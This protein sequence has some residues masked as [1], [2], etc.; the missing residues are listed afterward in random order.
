MAQITMYG[1][2]NNSPKTVVSVSMTA[3]D[4][5][6][7][8]ENVDAL[9]APPNL[10]TLGEDEN[11]EVISYS[12]KESNTLTGVVRGIKGTTASPWPAGTMVYRAYTA[13]DHDAFKANIEDL[14]NRKVASVNNVMPDDN[15]NILLSA[16][17]IEETASRVF[18]SPEQKTKIDTAYSTS[19]GPLPIENGGTGADN[20]ETARENLDVPQ[21]V[22]V[23]GHNTNFNYTSYNGGDANDIT[24]EFHEFVFNM[25][26]I[27]SSDSGYGFLDVSTTDGAG[28]APSDQGV[29]LQ[30]FYGYS[31]GRMFYRTRINGT[32]WSNWLC[33]FPFNGTYSGT[34]AEQTI[35]LGFQPRFVMVKK[36][37]ATNHWWADQSSGDQYVT[38]T[39]TGFRVSGTSSS[40]ASYSGASYRYIAWR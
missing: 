31:S 29:I 1:A 32:T 20:A 39:S 18:V 25:K 33:S 37:G 11:A 15:K 34:G 10:A 8:V 9:P 13:Y 22:N 6:I 30:K 5:T 4:T 35:S 19:S 3:S 40:G 17:D 38:I 28:F 26:N 27:P 23:L 16:D 12:G 36:I 7:Q 24:R 2:I 21:K 14:E